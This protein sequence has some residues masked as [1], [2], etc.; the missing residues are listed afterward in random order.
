M[1]F[2]GRNRNFFL[3]TD[4]GNGPDEFMPPAHHKLRSEKQWEHVTYA[5]AQQTTVLPSVD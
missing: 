1:I 4:Y 2:V 3:P 5:A